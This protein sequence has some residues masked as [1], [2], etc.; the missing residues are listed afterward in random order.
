[1]AAGNSC[2]IDGFFVCHEPNCNKKY[3]HISNLKYHASH[4]HSDNVEN[5]NNNDADEEDLQKQSKKPEVMDIDVTSTSRATTPVT[6][7]T[8]AP[9][10]KTSSP[11]P[12]ATPVKE[13][14]KVVKTEPIVT[15][16]ASP[17]LSCSGGINNSP[18]GITTSPGTIKAQPQQHP[19]M[20]VVSTLST[21]LPNVFPGSYSTNP[22]SS[23][24]MSQTSTR[25]VTA[26]TSV[27]PVGV[28][29]PLS[30]ARPVSPSKVEEFIPQTTTTNNGSEVIAISHGKYKLKI[31]GPQIHSN[32]PQS[33]SFHGNG[34]QAALTS[35]TARGTTV[36]IP[37]A[38]TS[39]TGLLVA[40]NDG[41]ARPKYEKTEKKPIPQIGQ[42]GLPVQSNLVTVPPKC[43]TGMT[44]NPPLKPIQP[45]PAR[46]V[47]PVHLQ[48]NGLCGSKDNKRSK[49]KRS[50]DKDSDAPQSIPASPGHQ[51]MSL[52]PPNGSTAPT[53][54]QGGTH[55]SHQGSSNHPMNKSSHPVQVPGQPHSMQQSFHIISHS[56]VSQAMN[57]ELLKLSSSKQGT[58]PPKS[59]TQPSG[60]EQKRLSNPSADQV[61]DSNSVIKT[62]PQVSHNRPP[63]IPP[64]VHNRPSSVPHSV[65]DKARQ[66]SASSRQPPPSASLSN[67]VRPETGTPTDTRSMDVVSPAY[68][69]ISDANDTGSVG[70]MEPGRAEGQAPGNPALNQDYYSRTSPYNM[71]APQQSVLTGMNSPLR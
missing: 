32:S 66:H 47:E 46:L 26:T 16:S 39:T 5:D 21:S 12:T 17:T 28:P 10:K 65:L 11:V 51:L 49:K 8:Q 3:R 35:S 15:Q 27:I 38:V 70:D 50:R 36:S 1:M 61:Y 19:P 55:L 31:S 43:S 41:K 34:S 62:V 23:D 64:P 24:V 57:Q 25:K 68:S 58:L 54:V 37:V 7:P 45:K 33:T 29:V 4:A 69:D 44:T 20:S 48:N 14:S 30:G 42:K 60:T 18:V 9:V 63:S 53:T 40:I 56:D 2:D 22:T 13:P 71:S 52:S 67:T 6:V 59:A